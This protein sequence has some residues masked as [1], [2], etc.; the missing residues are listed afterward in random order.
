MVRPSDCRSTAHKP[1]PR[2]PQK[3]APVIARRQA[4]SRPTG[5][6]TWRMTS[7][8]AWL[9]AKYATSSGRT[10]RSTRRS[11]RSVGAVGWT[12]LGSWN[13]TTTPLSLLLTEREPAEALVEARDLAAGVEQLLVAAGPCRMHLRVDVEVHGVAFLAPGRADLELGA[14]GHLDV[15][16]VIIGVDTGLHV[17]F[18]WVS[19]WF[20]TSHRRVSGAFI[21]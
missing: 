6:P 11:V 20:P 16:H 3:P 4:S 15:D 1:M 13:G 18:P 17:S 19:G 7:A 9:E 8:S 14:V 10:W 5:P 2:T 21:F 12:S